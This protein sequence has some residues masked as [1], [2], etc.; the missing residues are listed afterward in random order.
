M[1]VA[2]FYAKNVLALFLKVELP[3][4]IYYFIAIVLTL[5]DETKIS[6]SELH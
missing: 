4:S 2:Q 3:H 5:V 6:S 1:D